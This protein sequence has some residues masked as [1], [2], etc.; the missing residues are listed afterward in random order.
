M[1]K[2]YVEFLEFHCHDDEMLVSCVIKWSIELNISML[3]LGTSTKAIHFC[4]KNLL[5][6]NSWLNNDGDDFDGELQQQAC[7]IV[8]LVL[9]ELGR[10]AVSSTKW[11]F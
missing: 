1:Y 2:I 7:F 8:R 4:V 6:T 10:A 5:M 9:V 3:I 11:C